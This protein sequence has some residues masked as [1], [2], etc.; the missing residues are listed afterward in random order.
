MPSFRLHTLRM[1]LRNGVFAGRI[2]FRALLRPNRA[3]AGDASL[4]LTADFV[5]A[6][7][8]EWIGTSP[9]EKRARANNRQG[10]HL[11]ILRSRRSN[12][13]GAWLELLMG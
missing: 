5:G 13:S 10:L 7:L 12:A 11:L 9:G 3:L 1:S 4:K 6:A 8:F 2:I